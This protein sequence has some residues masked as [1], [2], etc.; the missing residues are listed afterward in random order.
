MVKNNV[1]RLLKS[2]KTRFTSFDLPKEKL[3]AIQTASILNVSPDKVFKSIVILRGKKGKPILAIVPGPREVD[4]KKLANLLGEKK[5]SV[6]SEREVEQVTGL[7]VGGI[8]PLALI[9]KGFEM[10]L[11]QSAHLYEDIHISGGQRGLNLLI[12]VQDLISL[13]YPKISDIT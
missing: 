2:R 6:L 10:V 3:N 11:D 13:I 12:N 4:L 7:Q 9:G 5:L 8:S 1:I